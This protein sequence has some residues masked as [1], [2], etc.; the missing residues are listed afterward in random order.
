MKSEEKCLARELRLQGHS[1]NE[2]LSRVAV[3][4]STLSLWLRDITLDDDQV[5]RLSNKQCVRDERFR[6]VLRNQ[7]LERWAT[8]HDEAR[9]EYE[10]L[11]QDPAFMFG[12][13]LY[14]GE[15]SKT[16]QGEVRITNCDAR[17]IQKGLRFFLLI[18]IPR[19]KVRCAVHIYPSLSRAEA[20]DYWQRTTGL[21]K[22]QFHMTR[23]TVSR[24]SSGRKINVQL[25]GTCQLRANDTKVRQK[26]SVWMDLALLCGPLV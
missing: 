11:S 7:R 26:L 5:S 18:G 10:T 14:V 3:S 4:K 22:S 19:E 25:Y 20:E 1:Y 6:Q 8:Y 9:R 12:L 21:L 23:D 2:I 13:A 15:G 24:A 17:V 16:K